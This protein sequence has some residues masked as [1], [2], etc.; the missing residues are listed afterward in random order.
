[1][2]KKDRVEIRL[3]KIEKLILEK[4]AEKVELSLSE[5]I[6]NNCLD[7]EI[8]SKFS[9]EEKEIL[10]MLYDIST[11]LREIKNNNSIEKISLIDNMLKT[12]RDCLILIYDR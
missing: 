5:Y 6:R 2:A 10:K 4:K 1:M 8:K 11:E 12:L 3:T 7:I 9:D